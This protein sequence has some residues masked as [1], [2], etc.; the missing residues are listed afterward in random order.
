MEPASSR[1]L[2][3]VLNLLS[4]NRN[5][6][7]FFSLRKTIIENFQPFPYLL[8][9]VISEYQIG[10]LNVENNHESFKLEIPM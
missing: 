3:W 1:T 2:C 9:L 4:Y 7:I 10:I 8:K 6:P 5:S